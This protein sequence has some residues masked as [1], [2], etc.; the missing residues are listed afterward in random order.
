MTRNDV[1]TE[2]KKL[3]ARYVGDVALTEQM[4][5][6]DDLGLDSIRVMD[7]VAD[8]QDHF[9]VEVPLGALQRLHTFGD[10]VSEVFEAVERK[11][12]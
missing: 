10:V 9:G 4:G 7:I 1:A 12:P 5:F 8:L 3:L 6:I 2:L 11:N